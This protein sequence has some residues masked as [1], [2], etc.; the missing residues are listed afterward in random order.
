MFEKLSALPTPLKWLVTLLFVLAVALVV[1][2]IILLYYLFAYKKDT[3]PESARKNYRK[4]LLMIAE[5][6]IFTSVGLVLDYL[7]SVIDIAFPNGGS[8]SIA[9]LPI[10]ILSYRWG[11]KGGLI[12]GFLIGI[13]QMIWSTYLTHPIVPFFDYILP[14]GVIGLAGLFA[15]LATSDK[16]KIRIPFIIISVVSVCTLRL[17]FHT[18][19]GMVAWSTPFGAS[20]LYNLSYVGIDAILCSA[21]AIALSF[22][23]KKYW[24][25]Q[26]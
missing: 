15:K 16:A 19:S 12:S 13:I 5:I 23:L 11:L 17:A 10:F 14:Y 2:L 9:M 24:R 20:L 3:N 18:I 22:A 8:I 26:G 4:L 1:G 25:Y 7:A 6:G 21:L